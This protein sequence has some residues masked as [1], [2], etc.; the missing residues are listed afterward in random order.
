VGSK[1]L[2]LNAGD[3]VATLWPRLYLD[4]DI[5]ITAGT[6]IAVLDRLAQGDVL[7]ARPAS[8]Y[9]SEGASVLVRSYYR[10]RERM[11]VNPQALWWAGVYGLSARGHE[12]FG[13]FPDITGDDMFRGHPIRTRR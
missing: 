5:Q 4:A 1:P 8:R 11:S 3:E 10:A 6:V 2:A 12:R 7:A 13:S 9:G